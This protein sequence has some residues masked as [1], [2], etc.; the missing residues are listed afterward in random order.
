MPKGN[1]ETRT[2]DNE[3]RNYS[4][5]EKLAIYGYWNSLNTILS[6]NAANEFATAEGGDSQWKPTVMLCLYKGQ[7]VA[8]VSLS[9][10]FTSDIVA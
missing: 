10:C 4:I 5:G 9:Y 6:T 8:R 3:P 7:A 2:E 1:T